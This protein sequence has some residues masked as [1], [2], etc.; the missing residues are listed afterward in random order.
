M[1]ANPN[2]ILDCVAGFDWFRNAFHALVTDVMSHAVEI[3]LFFTIKVQILV[4]NSM[5]FL[6]LSKNE[7]SCFGLKCMVSFGGLQYRRD[8]QCISTL[9]HWMFNVPISCYKY[10][11][12]LIPSKAV[13]IEKKERICSIIGTQYAETHANLSL[14]GPP[15]SCQAVEHYQRFFFK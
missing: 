13:F 14:Q 1:L 7:R 8:C 6:C 15:K 9:P 2:V 12:E 3:Y 5:N 10:I 4:K 11:C